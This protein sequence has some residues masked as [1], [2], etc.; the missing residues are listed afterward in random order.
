MAERTP[1]SSRSIHNKAVISGVLLLVLLLVL[2]FTRAFG[3][4]APGNGES[5]VSPPADSGGNPGINLSEELTPSPSPSLT[6]SPSPTPNVPLVAY[7]GVVEHL[8]LHPLVAYPVLAFDGDHQANGIDDWMITADE[9]IKI[10]E[11]LYENDYILVDIYSVYS[12]TVNEN[13]VTVMQRNTLRLPEGKKPLILS[14]D[15]VNYYD[16]MRENGFVYKLVLDDNGNIASWGLNPDGNE[17]VAYDLDIVTILDAFVAKHPDFSHNGAKGVLG[18]TGY[19]GILGYRTQA[20]SASR[21]S[22]IKAVKPVIERLKE[23]GWTFCSHSYGHID[24]A[25]SSYDRIVSDTTKWLDEVASL[26]GDT[27]LL[28]YPYGSRVD[29]NNGA[30]FQYLQS[31]G[32][33]MFLSVGIEPYTLIH[34]DSAAVCGDRMHPDGTTLRWY[35]ELYLRFYDAKDVINLDVRPDRGYDFS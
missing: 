34:T 3:A 29:E 9:Y 23:T 22:E 28:L 26:V 13:G 12:E 35:R 15:D 30:A 2:I 4:L 33:Q 18:L 31:A 14:F 7:D 32:F 8:F 1:P 6:P 17:V 10:L 16:Y 27:N 21:A 11:S 20:G 24:M 25:G 19:E 5:T